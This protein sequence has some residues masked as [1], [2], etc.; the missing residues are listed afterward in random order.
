MAALA[1][2]RGSG[3]PCIGHSGQGMLHEWLQG[4]L[5]TGCYLGQQDDQL[6]HSVVDIERSKLGLL[7][8]K[9]VHGI[10]KSTTKLWDAVK[11]D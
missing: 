6:N 8:L 2:N 7:N 5:L 10:D 9:S 11:I 3:D 4:L 1:F